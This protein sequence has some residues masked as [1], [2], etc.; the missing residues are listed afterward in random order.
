MDVVGG[1]YLQKN[2]D[3]LAM[4]GRL[5]QIGLLGGARSEVNLG[6]VMR[7]RLVIT[8]STLRPRSV[9]EKGS[10]ARELEANVWPLLAAGTVRPI[11]QQTFPLERAADAHRI[12][13]EGRLIGKV[14][15]VTA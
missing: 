1:D 15:L 13:E 8:G 11:L 10:I 5:I 4:D 2:I 7:K 12:M 3:C 6:P 9:S 14:V